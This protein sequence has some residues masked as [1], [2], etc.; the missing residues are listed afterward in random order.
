MEVNV[1]D[2]LSIYESHSTFDV[3]FILRIKGGLPKLNKNKS[4]FLG[5]AIIYFKGFSK[6]QY[7]GLIKH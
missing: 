6:P 5:I 7:S 2:I 3:Y 1:V 4:N